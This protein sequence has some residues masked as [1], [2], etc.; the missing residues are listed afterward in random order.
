MTDAKK[1]EDLENE[2]LQLLD[3]GMNMR[4]GLST[5]D[6]DYSL[7]FIRQK[8]ALCSTY[9]E[10]L[11][12]IMMKLSR[13]SLETTRVASGRHRL[14]EMKRS[15]LKGSTTYAEQ[16]RDQKTPWLEG[17]LQELREEAERWSSL[18]RVVS[19]VKEAIVERAQTMKRLDS[20]LR[21]HTRLI[22]VQGPEGQGATSPK[23]YTGT[24]STEVDID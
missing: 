9:Q 19:E 7:H 21:L 18:K 17:K 23:A 22:E 2:V 11:S 10:R 16:P 20:D 13:I 6:S 12:D 5:D 8:V 24:S 1:P 3:D 4:L 15:E 14:L